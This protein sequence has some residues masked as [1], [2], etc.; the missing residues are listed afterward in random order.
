LNNEIDGALAFQDFIIEH[1][2]DNHYDAVIITVPPFN[3]LKLALTAG[4]R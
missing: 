4:V 2:K 3:M 1:L